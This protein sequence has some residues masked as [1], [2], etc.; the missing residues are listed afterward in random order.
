MARTFAD[1][2]GEVI[3]CL[4]TPRAPL[5]RGPEL[6]APSTGGRVLYRSTGM[7][8]TGPVVRMGNRLIRAPGARCVPAQG[9]VLRVGQTTCAGGGDQANIWSTTPPVCARRSMFAEGLRGSVCH[10]VLLLG[11]VETAMLETE[12]GFSRLV[13]RP[14]RASIVRGERCRALVEART[15]STGLPP[16]LGGVGRHPFQPPA[17]PVQSEF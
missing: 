4:R 15:R 16:K 17:Q 2:C 11:L 8:T 14:T 6:P 5:L 7:G 1:G 13:L 9:L 3:N 10:S 12:V